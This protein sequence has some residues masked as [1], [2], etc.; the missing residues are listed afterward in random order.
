[1]LRSTASTKYR[2]YPGG[3]EIGENFFPITSSFRVWLYFDSLIRAPETETQDIVDFLLSQYIEERPR[4]PE[5]AVIGALAFYQRKSYEETAR[6]FHQKQEGHQEQGGKKPVPVF[7]FDYD[8]EPIKAAFLQAYNIDLETV[9]DLHWHRFMALFEYLPADT[10]IKQRI[11]YRGMDLGKI[12]DKKERERVR[13]IQRSIRIP[14][15]TKPTDGQIGNA[16]W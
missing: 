11:H 7:D 15:K 4:D 3:V 1:M 12:S 14:S 6:R 5:K 10:E 13:R 8:A 9:E 2:P 16:F